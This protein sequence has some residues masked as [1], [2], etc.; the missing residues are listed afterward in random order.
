[1]KRLIYIVSISLLVLTCNKKDDD[2]SSGDNGSISFEMLIGGP[3]SEL[4]K[5]DLLGN[6]WP[7]RFAVTSDHLYIRDEGNNRVQRF[8]MTMNAVDWH[9]YIYGEGYG[10]RTDNK[11]GDD[12]IKNIQ[13]RNGHLYLFDAFL[14]SVT[15]LKTDISSG[16]TVKTMKIG[17]PGTFYG[18]E[19][20]A[21]DNGGHIYIQFDNKMYKYDE[22]GNEV[23]SYEANSIYFTLDDDDNLYISDASN[24]A[25]SGQY[26]IKKFDSNGNLITSWTAGYYIDAILDFYNGKLYAYSVSPSNKIIQF[27]TSG[28]SLKSWSA[29]STDMVNARYFKVLDGRI[30]F[31]STD[32][33]TFAVYKM[34]GQ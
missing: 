27:S 25:Q 11:A 19:N 23:L 21:V 32:D 16:D 5:F 2:S 24:I 34:T 14:G 30:I 33:H 3:G 4:G 18:K 17:N 13:I 28:N 22:G 10:Y 6:I 20:F 29:P 7:N 9:G 26:D 12:G 15:I 31:P 8:D 1:M